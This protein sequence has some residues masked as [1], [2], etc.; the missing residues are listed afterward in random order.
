[1]RAGGPTK[2][3]QEVLAELK[4]AVGDYFLENLLDYAFQLA[5]LWR[6]HKMQWV[7]EIWPLSYVAFVLYDCNI[8]V[9]VGWLGG[10]GLCTVLC[11]I[12]H[13][14]MYAPPSL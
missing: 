10:W 6:T 3:F 4:M 9:V 5:Q 11:C 2:L 13:I 12:D 14:Y 1:M 8:V 7:W